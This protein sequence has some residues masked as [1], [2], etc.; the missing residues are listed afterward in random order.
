MDRCICAGPFFVIR[1]FLWI[2]RRLII[3]G[4][5]FVRSLFVNGNQTAILNG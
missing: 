2:G 1:V 3:G 5:H 4:G